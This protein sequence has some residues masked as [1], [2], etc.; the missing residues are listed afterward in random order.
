M[1]KGIQAGM[2]A[3][4][5]GEARAYCGTRHLPNLA[6]KVIECDCGTCQVQWRVQAVYEKCGPCVPLFDVMH[7]HSRLFGNDS[8]KSRQ[9][10]IRR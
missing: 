6:D 10:V 4:S 2:S 8:V 3:F 7:M 1:T 5:S 9:M